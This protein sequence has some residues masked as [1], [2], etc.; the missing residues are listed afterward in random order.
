MYDGIDFNTDELDDDFIV[1]YNEVTGYE[2]DVLPTPEQCGVGLSDEEYAKKLEKVRLME[3]EDNNRMRRWEL[4][5]YGKTDKVYAYGKDWKYVPPA[6]AVVVNRDN[7]AQYWKPTTMTAGINTPYIND[8]LEDVKGPNAQGSV[9]FDSRTNPNKTMVI[10]SGD[11]HFKKMTA[12][13]KAVINMVESTSKPNSGISLQ[14]YIN[15]EEAAYNARIMSENNSNTD[16]FSGYINQGG[17]KMSGIAPDVS[18]YKYD[19]AQISAI[20]NGANQLFNG[21]TPEQVAAEWEQMSKNNVPIHAAQDILFGGKKLVQGENGTFQNV[22]AT[23]A[24]QPTTTVNVNPGSTAGLPAGLSLYT[25]TGEISPFAAGVQAAFSAYDTSKVYIPS[26]AD[27][28]AAR[29]QMNDLKLGG[30]TATQTATASQP[31]VNNTQVPPPVQTQAPQAG[32]D[33][34]L[35]QMMQRGVNNY[36]QAQAQMQ[37]NPA[38]SADLLN[39][40]MSKMANMVQANQ[41]MAPVPEIHHTVFTADGQDTKGTLREQL[42]T[43]S[44]MLMTGLNSNNQDISTAINII[45]DL[46]GLDQKELYSKQNLGIDYNTFSKVIDQLCDRISTVTD[47]TGYAVHQ[48]IIKYVQNTIINGPNSLIEPLYFYEMLATLAFEGY[49]SV[50]DTYYPDLRNSLLQAILYFQKNPMPI[51]AKDNNHPDG[52][53][54]MVPIIFGPNGLLETQMR[55]LNNNN[56]VQPTVVPPVAT[57]TVYNAPNNNQNLQNN[58]GGNRNMNS[59]F[60]NYNQRQ[61][62]TTGATPYA[63]LYA[64]YQGLPASLNPAA[65][66]ANNFSYVGAGSTVTNTGNY[67]PAMSPNN[68]YLNGGGGSAFAAGIQAA[69]GT[70]NPN[71]GYGAGYDSVM[72]SAKMAATVPPQPIVNTTYT[73]YYQQPVQAP[74]AISPRYAQQPVANTAVYGGAPQYQ[75]Q[76]MDMMN[77]MMGMFGMMLNMLSSIENVGGRNVIDVRNLASMFGGAGG[78]AGVVERFGKSQPQNNFN[79]YYGNFGGAGAWGTNTYNYNNV[80]NTNNTR[81]AGWGANTVPTFTQNTSGWGTST[82]TYNSGLGLTFSTPAPVATGLNLNTTA[83]PVFNYNPAASVGSGVTNMTFGG[84][85]GAWG[86]NTTYTNTNTG[87]NWGGGNTGTFG[88]NQGF[89]N[90]TAVQNNGHTIFGRHG[91]DKI[92][93]VLGLTR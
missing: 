93:A 60:D 71:A 68:I 19:P 28:A 86:T 84:N 3:M 43:L 23:P 14:A 33:D 77:N 69:L 79:N 80:W 37:Q 58:L 91:E 16:I 61:F 34:P 78:G 17:N 39:M 40:V 42:L 13:E 75:Q 88:G 35:L 50:A 65:A 32:N 92:A 66:G 45:M 21:K 74:A 87:F 30:T 27:M 73:Q 55:F 25:N 9:I 7:I 63:A 53:L 85:S 67:G 18:T 31:V 38:A 26:A 62:T 24:A 47:G 76:P 44:D 41:T 90:N 5:T 8:A 1:Y 89:V 15:M 49:I 64:G 72:G 11:Q 51:V 70:Y 36:N 54:N 29:Q 57:Q 56:Q 52:K 6:M 20:V 22:S 82:P 2:S 10:A 48:Q 83:A 4:Q 81:P 59:I 12:R 46:A